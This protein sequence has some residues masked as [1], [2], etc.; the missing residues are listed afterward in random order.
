M[1]DGAVGLVVWL[2]IAVAVVSATTTAAIAW[3]GTYS[4]NPG[5]TLLF[6]YLMAFGLYRRSRMCAVTLLVSHLYTRV[7]LLGRAFDL[8]SAFGFVGRAALY[9]WAVLATFVYQGRRG[10]PPMENDKKR[11]N[12]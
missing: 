6:F 1:S 4:V 10:L 11:R 7:D 5:W 12:A 9:A 3:K 2:C 8:A